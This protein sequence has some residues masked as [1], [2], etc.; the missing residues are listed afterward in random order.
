VCE[1]KKD[2]DLASRPQIQFLSR[3]TSLTHLKKFKKQ[4]NDM[5][6]SER[7]TEAGFKTDLSAMT[8]YEAM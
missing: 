4:T 5:H 2:N 6:G 8:P 1:K 3:T 7:V